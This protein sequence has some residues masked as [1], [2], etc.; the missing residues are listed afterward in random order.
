ME[1]KQ[2][3]AGMV[4]S[5]LV[6]STVMAATKAKESDYYT[7]T[8]VPVPEGVVLEA[9]GIELMPDKTLAV[10]SRRGDIYTIKNAWETPAKETVWTPFAQ[11]LH[12]PIGLSYYDGY[13]WTAQR[14]EVTRM[15]D[16]TGDGRADVFDSM[17]SDWGI[18]GDYHEYAFGSRHDK[19]GNM[20]LVM[21]LTGSGGAKS[22]FRG[23]CLRVSKDGKMIPTTSGIR[24]P[25]GI[26]NNING[27]MFYCDNQGL[28]NG[29]SCLKHLKVGSFQGNPSGN[30]YYDLTDAIGKRPADPVSDSRIEIERKRIPEF[31]PPAIIL[32]HGK[33]GKS[34]SGIEPDSSKGNFGPFAGQLLVLDQGFSNITRCDLEVVNGVYQGAA[35]PFLSGFGSGSVSVR[36]SPDGALFVGGTERGWGSKG[37]HSFRLER[38]NWTGKLPFEIFTMRLSKK[39]W[40]LTFTKEID[41]ASVADV[42]KMLM[43]SHT[44]IYKSG[45]GSP[46]VDKSE[47][48]IQSVTIGQDGKSIDLVVDGRVKGNVH[49]LHLPALTSKDGELLLHDSVHYTLNEFR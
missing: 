21:C 19:D 27:D 17:S 37:P 33:L 6:A 42:T 4:T 36:M 35:I 13:L 24:S 12:E 22:D 39:G 1:M 41:P 16:V 25:G 46:E 18:N 34:S 20:W 43:T 10:C 49:V 11:G 30:I 15:K 14:C 9:V 28:W 38:A 3:L 32:T 31:V 2:I 44:Y 8:E 47:P 29:S 26:G 5:M 48:V 40:K 45:Y 7:I 23:W